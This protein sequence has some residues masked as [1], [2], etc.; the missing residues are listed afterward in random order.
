[1]ASQAMHRWKRVARVA[2]A[3][4]M[5]LALTAAAGELPAY[6]MEAAFAVGA[7]LIIWGSLKAKVEQ[8]EKDIERKVNLD[9]YTQ[10]FERLDRLEAK[11]DRLLER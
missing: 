9:V 5:G 10:A 2:G 7:G 4:L 1:M 6:V 11:L 8:L 3:V